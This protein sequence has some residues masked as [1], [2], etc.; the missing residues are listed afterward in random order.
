MSSPTSCYWN[1]E[2]TGMTLVQSRTSWRQPPVPSSFSAFDCILA[3]FRLL[4][5][6]ACSLNSLWACSTRSAHTDRDLEESAGRTVLCLTIERRNLIETRTD[7]SIGQYS[8]QRHVI[9]HWNNGT[10]SIEPGHHFIFR[11]WCKVVDVEPT[12]SQCR[13]SMRR[14]QFG[15]E[16][17]SYRE[18]YHRVSI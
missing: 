11:H 12:R 6:I 10:D 13:A 4:N 16:L 7:I 9:I 5:R 1:S 3:I 15:V 2:R 14:N 17:W 18:F 8:K